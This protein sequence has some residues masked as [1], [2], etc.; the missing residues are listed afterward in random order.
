MSIF[1]KLLSEAINDKSFDDTDGLVK[2]VKSVLRKSSLSSYREKKSGDGYVEPSRHGFKFSCL[3]GDCTITFMGV[4]KSSINE[5]ASAL[6]KAKVNYKYNNHTESFLISSDDNVKS[7]GMISSEAKEELESGTYG[8]LDTEAPSKKEI[9]NIIN[10]FNSVQKRIYNEL[11][12]Y[13]LVEWALMRS[14]AGSN[15]KFVYI[16]NKKDTNQ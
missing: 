15:E 2:A 6:G 5:I 8:V 12:K 7:D 9:K 3:N 11:L 16:L 13:E 10:D 14:R 4:S 1:Q